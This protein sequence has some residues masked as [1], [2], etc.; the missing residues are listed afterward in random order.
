MYG[1][2]KRKDS[3]QLSFI[4]PIQNTVF[5]GSLSQMLSTINIDT[6]PDM[7][8]LDSCYQQHLEV[9]TQINLGVTWIRE[10]KL[11]LH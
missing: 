7:S 3:I 2:Q 5:K 11:V 4:Y 9:L 6:D 1:A 10:N 8:L